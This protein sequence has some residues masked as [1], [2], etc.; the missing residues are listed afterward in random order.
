MRLFSLVR[1]IRKLELY[2]GVETSQRRAINGV[3]KF[4]VSTEQAAETE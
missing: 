4:A 2:A 3:V 1:Q